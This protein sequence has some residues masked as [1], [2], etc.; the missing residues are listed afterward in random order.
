M[1]NV[2]SNVAQVTSRMRTPVRKKG[3]FGELLLFSSLFCLFLVGKV[4]FQTC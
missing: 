1:G 2:L 4:G 3:T